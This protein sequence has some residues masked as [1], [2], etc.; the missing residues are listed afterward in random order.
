MLPHIVQVELRK[1]RCGAGK[2]E[3]NPGAIGA[4]DTFTLLRQ[5]QKG[6]CSGRA[7]ILLQNKGDTHLQCAD[8]NCYITTKSV[9]RTWGLGEHHVVYFPHK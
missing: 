7:Y 4:A 5:Q 6:G 9:Y 1:T 8:L 2:L 3:E